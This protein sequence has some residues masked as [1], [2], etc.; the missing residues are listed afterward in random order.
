MSKLA[1]PVADNIVGASRKNLKRK[2]HKTSTKA[3]TKEAIT[4]RSKFS[5]V[6]LYPAKNVKISGY[7]SSAHTENRADYFDL[8]RYACSKQL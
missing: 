6:I 3:F 4:L 2:Y 1:S 7:L 8:I 5:H